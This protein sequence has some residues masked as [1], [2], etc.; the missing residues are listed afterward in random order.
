MSLETRGVTEQSSPRVA[1]HGPVLVV[2]CLALATVV[3][4]VASLNVAIPSIA[5]DTHATLTQL[6]W[7][8]D[9]YAL[10]F[11]ALLLPG[12]AVGD[13]FGRRKALLVGLAVF[14]AGSAAAMLEADATWLIAMRAVLGLGAALVMPATLSTITSTFPAAQRAKAVGTWAGVAGASAIL[15]LLTSGVVLEWWSWRAVFAVNVVLAV[16]AVVGTL[17]AV[18]ESA[19]PEAPRLDL[20]G[21]L[22]ALVS[23]A[24]LVYSIIEAPTRGWTDVRTVVGLAA[25]LVGLAG[26]VV[27]EARRA[28][29]L[30]DPR[31]FTYRGFA[32][33]T[34]TITVQF[35]AFFGFIFLVLQYLQ[36]VLADSPL[37]AA[38][39]LVPLAF[40]LMPTA[41]VLAPRLADRIGTAR[42]SVAGLVIASAALGWLST[43]DSGSSYWPL[44][45]GLVPLG[46]GMALAM[47]PA[48][49]AITDALP[50]EKQGV[51][52]ATNDLARELGGALGIAVLGSVLQ[53]VYRSNLD[54]NGLSAPAADQAR[55]SL[56]LA[57]RL[58]PQVAASAA[59]SF[60]DGFRIALVVGAAALLVAAVG[61]LA[62]QLSSRADRL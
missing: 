29:P 28:E 7:V 49:A 51:G 26:F 32:A 39:S 55:S 54:V 42:T 59:N 60:V 43:L 17:R 22:V 33:G 9:A 20:T 62:L 37:V 45:V 44:L 14:G 2:M 8:V 30:L 16:A 27:V 18:P 50:R 12:G 58:G 15:G 53:S 6:S 41:R 25:A 35:F 31:L 47:T 48:T 57:L 46:A 19:D 1:G 10:V 21:A 23:L 5:R 13:R 11:A 36:L 38:L 40:G 61:V 24:V 4:A 3:S 52:S 34:L 56:A